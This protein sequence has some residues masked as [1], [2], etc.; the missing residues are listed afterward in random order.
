MD[1]ILNREFY[2]KHYRRVAAYIIRNSG[3]DDEAQDA[4]QE[5]WHATLLR[6]RAGLHIGDYGRFLFECAKNAYLK[7]CKRK[8]KFVHFDLLS[9]AD[10]E[11]EG[12]DAQAAA[13][14]SAAAA[15]AEMADDTVEEMPA[16]GS[17]EASALPSP[18]EEENSLL[19]LSN[20]GAVGAAL[21]LLSALHQRILH[22]SLALGQGN[23]A[24]AAEIGDYTEGSMAV[25]KS[26][27]YEALRRATARL[28]HEQGDSYFKKIEERKKA[29][30]AARRTR[31]DKRVTMNEEPTT[32][33]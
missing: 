16:S 24:I 25:E 15:L 13:P 26:R 19:H 31:D 4:F 9:S 33:N 7:E 32:D 3:T 8:Q 5:A 1:D 2:K 6:H 17:G 30:K 20:W 22:L 10:E 14:R 29:E 21:R 28:L 12:E 27:A 11:P 23:A 18:D